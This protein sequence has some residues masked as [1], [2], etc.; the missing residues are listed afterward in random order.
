M[1][2][3]ARYLDDTT[4]LEKYTAYY[5]AMKQRIN[6]HAWDGNWYVR[7]FDADGKP[8][9]SR[10]NTQ[11]QIYTNGQTWPVISGLAPTDRARTAL[12]SVYARLNTRHGIKL[13]TPGFDGY[14]PDKGGITTYPPGAK[15]NGGIF[16]HANPWVIIAET[17]L[18]NGDRA[19]EYYNQINPAAQNNRI[20]E[21]ECEPYVYA[22][23]ILG[24]EHPQF[25]LARNSWL[26]GTAAWTY[27]AG[28]KYILGI[29]PDY[30][31]LQVDPCIPDQWEGF[32][33]T[34]TFRNA[35]YEI[36]V[37]NPEHVCKG[38][39]SL[40]V[41]GKSI[42]GNIAPIFED[43]QTHQVVVKLGK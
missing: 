15:E 17:I 27:Q 41:D 23:N 32:K 1:I 7:Y 34:R 8:L 43:G 26:S 36:E 13:S 14:N 21:F 18:G 16:L 38:V 33:A 24:D 10:M 9:G 2:D 39:K 5:L 25:G 42:R 12:D 37:Q 30:E 40:T 31:G 22:Q 6:K 3:L 11:G 20:D 29:R 4:S 19:F 28:T 35:H